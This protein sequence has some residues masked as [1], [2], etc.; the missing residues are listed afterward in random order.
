MRA[1]K[2]S[3]FASKPLRFLLWNNLHYP[4]PSIGNSGAHRLIVEVVAVDNRFALEQVHFCG[5]DAR[6]SL[7]SRL[8]MH[9]AMAAAHTFDFQQLSHGLFLSLKYWIKPARLQPARANTHFYN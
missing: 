5:F 7:E 1:T 8:H 6:H 4:V 2:A 9:D 3:L